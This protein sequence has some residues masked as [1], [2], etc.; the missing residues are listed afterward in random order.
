MYDIDIDRLPRSNSNITGFRPPLLSH[1]VCVQLSRS[2]RN[3]AVLPLVPPRSYWT[4]RGR[5]RLAKDAFPRSHATYR[6]IARGIRSG[7]L[8]PLCDTLLYSRWN[9]CRVVLPL[10]LFCL[11]L[12]GRSTRHPLVATRC[13]E[14]CSAPTHLEEHH[15]FVLPLARRTDWTS[16]ARFF[17]PVV[18]QPSQLWLE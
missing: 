6:A 15:S 2:S 9:S 16:N 14:S 4:F 1:R 12:N 7:P 11:A 13:F 18:Q 8:G 3:D 17:P 10:V 5:P